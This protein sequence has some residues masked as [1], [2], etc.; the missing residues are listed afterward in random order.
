MHAISYGHRELIELL[1]E[2]GADVNGSD[3]ATNH[4]PLHVA[5]HKGDIETVK[6]LLEKGAKTD[7]V[8]YDHGGSPTTPLLC[9]LVLGAVHWPDNADTMDK[10]QSILH[11]IR[12]ELVE[13]MLEKGC[14]VNLFGEGDDTPLSVCSGIGD[15]LVMK[16]LVEA[17][18]HLNG[19]AGPS[20]DDGW[21]SRPKSPIAAAVS[22][23]KIE[24]ILFLIQNGADVYC[25]IKINEWSGRQSLVEYAL[26]QYNFNSVLLLLDAGCE[27]SEKARGFVTEKYASHFPHESIRGKTNQDWTSPLTETDWSQVNSCADGGSEEEESN[28]SVESP[29]DPD[30]DGRNDNDSLPDT[31]SSASD[32]DEDADDDEKLTVRTLMVKLDEV[33]ALKWRLRVYLRRDLRLF[34]PTDVEMLPLPRSLKDYLLC[35]DLKPQSYRLK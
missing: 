16:L 9:A 21:S 7:V 29:A 25:D 6:V 3:A 26:E 30:G 28:E 18:A 12:H 5:A 34:T 19:S 4:T 11:D 35:L 13:L 10:Y 24:A 32:P 20:R 2:K 17:G 22:A 33:K 15:I 8:G 27:V 23:N 31:F 14:D 1:L